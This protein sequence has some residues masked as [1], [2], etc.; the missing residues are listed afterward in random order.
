MHVEEYRDK[1]IKAFHDSGHDELITFVPVADEKEINSLRDLLTLCRYPL[2]SS[3]EW[4]H[5]PEGFDHCEGYTCSNCKRSFYVR[6]PYFAE[7]KYCPECGAYMYE[8]IDR[9]AVI[10]IKEIEKSRGD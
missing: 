3:G 1:L 10:K 5:E 2:R 9:K 7:Y 4:I 6:V 8:E